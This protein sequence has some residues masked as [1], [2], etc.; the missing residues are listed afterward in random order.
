M[1]NRSMIIALV[2]GGLALATTNLTAQDPA[3]GDQPQSGQ[4]GQYAKGTQSA[5]SLTANLKASTII[6]LSVRNDSGDRLG[7][8]KDLIVN[9]HSRA[10]P[11]AVIEY[12]GALGIGETCVAVPLTDL[13]WSSTS[14]EFILSAT[15]DQFDAASSAPTGGWMAFAD[16]DWVKGVNRFYGQP[17]AAGTARYERQEI[18]GVNEGREP[19]RNPAEQKGATGL[20][21][22]TGTANSAAASMLNAPPDR[23]LT[24]QV[25]SLIRH[26]EGDKA[27]QIHA[28]V[29]GGVVKLTGTIASDSD[30]KA[31]VHQ[32]MG[33]PGV[34]RVEDNLTTPGD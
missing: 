21:Q 3:S 32:I 34:T 25:N 10:V 8:V 28:T 29:D 12:G 31:L 17:A 23:A 24:S 16:Q 7:K 2:A 20:E 9:L 4:P 19:V 13:K 30:K 6:G 14:R 18:S 11:C 22:Q 5:Q 33:L 1:R 26:D 15:K 27:S